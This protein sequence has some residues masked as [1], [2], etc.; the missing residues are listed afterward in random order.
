MFNQTPLSH[1]RLST[2]QIF[3]YA[4]SSNVIK[5]EKFGYIGDTRVCNY[6]YNLVQEY[7]NEQEVADPTTPNAALAFTPKPSNQSFNSLKNN[8]SS[9][10][11]DGSS[12]DGLRRMMGVFGRKQDTDSHVPFRQDLLDDEKSLIN[13]DISADNT[14]EEEIEPYDEGGDLDTS[15]GLSSLTSGGISRSMTEG[16]SNHPILPTSPRTSEPVEAGDTD[17]YAKLYP[18][19]ISLGAFYSK[20]LRRVKRRSFPASSTIKTSK[21]SARTIMRQLSTQNL[22]GETTLSIFRPGHKRSVSV[23]PKVELNAVSLKYLKLLLRQVLTD[24]NLRLDEWEGVLMKLLLKV[25]DNVDPDVRKGDNMNIQHYVKIKRLPGGK[26]QDST[27]ING[28]IFSKNVANKKM[29]R[30]LTNPRVLLLSFSLEYHRVEN[31]LMSLEPILSQESEHLKNLVNRILSHT[32]D[33]II[34]E[35]TVSRLA[36][37]FLLDA[38]VAVMYSV[39]SSVMAALARLTRGDLVSSFSALAFPVILGSCKQFRTETYAHKAITEGKKSLA[40]FE[41]VPKNLGCCLIIRGQE[42]EELSKVKRCLRFLATTIYS[43]K[44]ETALLRDKMAVL[45]DLLASDSAS[46]HADLESALSADSIDWN[47]LLEAYKDATISSSPHVRIPPPFV[48]QELAKRGKDTNE[49]REITPG[50]KFST[51]KYDGPIVRREELLTFHRANLSPFNHSTISVLHTS[52]VAASNSPCIHHEPLTVH[53]YA[54]SDMALGQYLQELC[55]N[56]QISCPSKSCLKAMILHIQT[57]TH[58]NAR[59]TIVL[60]GM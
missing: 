29:V 59:L 13:L 50:C 33:L 5:G 30:P 36:L 4:C 25:C 58:N 22:S 46:S 32:P 43:L 1:G 60:E 42:M 45:P 9:S 56:A 7:R 23:P 28:L 47:K 11:G 31:Q 49:V 37:D 20:E 24:L 34:V 39:K 18:S 26:P 44:L 3:C 55:N 48:L 19:N 53:L 2:G 14:I 8:F 57:Y 40:V 27:Y 54:Q 38:N 52:F 21:Y 10:P 12:I 51:E 16:H 17:A 6:C 41:G 15:W 35:K